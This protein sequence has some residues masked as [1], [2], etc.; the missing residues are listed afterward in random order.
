[1]TVGAAV[2][3]LDSASALAQQGME[4]MGSP[5]FDVGGFNSR[6]TSLLIDTLWRNALVSRKRCRSP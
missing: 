3:I 1:M 2:L 6:I 5:K 4:G